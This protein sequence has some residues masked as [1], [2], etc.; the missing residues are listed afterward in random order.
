MKKLIFPFILFL[1]LSGCNPDYDILRGDGIAAFAVAVQS[2]VINVTPVNCPCK[3]TGKIQ[4]GDGKTLVETKCPCGDNCKCKKEENTV[5][6]KIQIL[7]IGGHD[8]TPCNRFMKKIKPSL[9]KSGWTF[10]ENGHIKIIEW[11]EE[12]GQKYDVPGIPTFIRYED[13]KETQRHEGYLN[14]LGVSHLQ[15]GKP[16]TKEDMK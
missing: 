12:I 5:T 9:E 13:G 6:K 16:L 1:S 7:Y 15:Q 10:G 3:G 2:Q 4:G 8:C 11:T 14:A